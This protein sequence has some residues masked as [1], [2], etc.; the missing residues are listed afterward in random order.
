M[1]DFKTADLCDDFDTELNI[2]EPK[3]INFGQR[4]RFCGVVST[5]KCFEDNSLVREAVSSPGDERV[6]VVDGS[7]SMR[8][9][10]L[11]DQLAELAVKN[12]WSGIIINGCIRDSYEISMMAIG[13]KALAT[14][15]LKSVKLGVG[16]RDVE[17]NISGV[18]IRPGCYVYSDEDGIVVAEKALV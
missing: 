10:L 15:P 3:F 18:S 8:C 17:V 6:L 5:V 13:V 14:F 16:E 9:A 7:A 11:G 12:N 2:L 4:S 1:I